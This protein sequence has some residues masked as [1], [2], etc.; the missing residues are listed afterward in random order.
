MDQCWFLIVRVVRRVG[1]LYQVGLLAVF[2]VQCGADGTYCFLFVSP[3]SRKQ[4]IDTG[5]EIMCEVCMF[6]KLG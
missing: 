5:D 4:V 1:V 3:P 2:P 6:W